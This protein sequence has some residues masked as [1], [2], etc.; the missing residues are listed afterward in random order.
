V[1]C[2]KFKKIRWAILGLY[3]YID[4]GVFQELISN[5]ELWRWQEWLHP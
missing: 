1:N 3:V 4:N 2:N 5:N